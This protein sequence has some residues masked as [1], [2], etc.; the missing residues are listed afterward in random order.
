M[1]LVQLWIG[2]YVATAVPEVVRK[3]TKKILAKTFCPG[4]GEL[5]SFKDQNHPNHANHVGW[6]NQAAYL[7]VFHPELA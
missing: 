6:V 1:N 4:C 7:Q 3:K 5:F 2:R